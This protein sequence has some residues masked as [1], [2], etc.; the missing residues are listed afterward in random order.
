VTALT[1]PPLV[2]G[3]VPVELSADGT[4]L[5]ALFTGQDMSVGFTVNPASGRTR[6]LSRDF[7]SGLVGFDLSADGRTILGHTGG[8]SM[9]RSH[10]VVRM[11]FGGGTPRVLVEDAGFPDWSR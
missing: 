4:R 2:S 10:D 9:A 11:P 5:L 7:E 8:P 6:A 3:L 1:I